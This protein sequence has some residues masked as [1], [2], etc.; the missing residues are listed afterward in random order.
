MEFVPV[1]AVY[2]FAH[3]KFRCFYDIN[4]TTGLM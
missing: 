2:K 1:T 3:Q 4:L